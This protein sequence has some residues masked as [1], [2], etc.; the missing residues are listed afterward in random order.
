MKLRRGVRPALAVVV[1]GLLLTGCGQLTPGT[2]AVVNGTRIPDSAVDDFVEAQCV[3]ADAAKSSGQAQP[4]SLARLR[5]QSLR[6]LVDN[7]LS[8]QYAASEGVTPS[9]KLA[10]AFYSQI[11]SGIESLPASASERLS[12]VGKELSEARAG[13]VEV[14][15]KT[16]GQAPTESNL[17]QLLAAGAQGQQKWQEKAEIDTDPRYSPDASGLPGT[18][19]GSVSEAGSSFAKSAGKETLDPSFVSALPA[20]QR[21][22]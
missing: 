15:A 1:S 5:T 12:V 19:S 9:E 10:T 13:L 21:C 11:Q 6:L 17:Q 18:G 22:G 20:G 14:G 4:E 16:T 2:A 3:V 8:L 7:R